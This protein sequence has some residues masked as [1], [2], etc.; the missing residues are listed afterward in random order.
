MIF[1]TLMSLHQELHLNQLL[2]RAG[3]CWILYHSNSIKQKHTVHDSAQLF[4]FQWEIHR[5]TDLKKG[6]DGIFLA[7]RY[8]WL[9]YCVFHAAQY[10]ETVESDQGPVSDSP[11]KSQSQIN[12]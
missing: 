6:D 12:E 2:L 5:E 8:I 10:R 4:D 9:S 7:I 3:L 1:Y 11:C